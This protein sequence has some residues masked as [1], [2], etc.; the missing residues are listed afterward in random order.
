MKVCRTRNRLNGS[1]SGMW[2]I[3]GTSLVVSRDKTSWYVATININHVQRH[4]ISGYPLGFSSHANEKWIGDN[5]FVDEEGRYTK[6]STRKQALDAVEMAL[7]SSPA[8]WPS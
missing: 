4:G 2:R 6:F 1:S 7:Q 3:Q 5:G 8:P